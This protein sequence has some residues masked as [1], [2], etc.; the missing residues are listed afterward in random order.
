MHDLFLYCVHGGLC[1]SDGRMVSV[2]GVILPETSVTVKPYY[3][4]RCYTPL[5]LHP[6]FKL[7]GVGCAHSGEVTVSQHGVRYMSTFLRYFLKNLFTISNHISLFYYLLHVVLYTT[8]IHPARSIIY[9]F[10]NLYNSYINFGKMRKNRRF[11]ICYITCITPGY[12]KLEQAFAFFR[13]L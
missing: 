11:D 3:L 8:F 6:C 12:L 4:G 10:Y 9:M 7:S 13:I 2:F 1:D 5:R